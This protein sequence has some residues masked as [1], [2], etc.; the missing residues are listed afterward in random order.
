MQNTIIIWKSI[1]SDPQNANSIDKRLVVVFP[2]ESKNEKLLKG[3]FSIEKNMGINDMM[4]D[5]R[6]PIKIS[7]D[8]KGLLIR[9]KVYIYLFF[10]SKTVLNHKERIMHSVLKKCSAHMIK[11]E[12]EMTSSSFSRKQIKTLYTEVQA[13]YKSN[14]YFILSLGSAKTTEFAHI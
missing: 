6:L 10:G 9:D 5:E 14:Q 12:K 13:I 2:R 8:K 7:K 1:A 4:P 3:I 11:V